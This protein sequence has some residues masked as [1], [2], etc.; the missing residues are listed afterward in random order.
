MGTESDILVIFPG[1]ASWK[2]AEPWSVIF[3]EL[4]APTL[5]HPAYCDKFNPELLM[6]REK[7]IVSRI[8]GD[9]VKF[10]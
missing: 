2:V 8:I 10:P 5:Y 3:Q 4:Y 1:L 6:K 7:L 9:S